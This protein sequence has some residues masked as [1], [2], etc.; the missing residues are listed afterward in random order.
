MAGLDSDPLEVVIFDVLLIA[1]AAGGR[2]KRDDRHAGDVAV[3]R[4]GFDR[5]RPE[6]DHLRRPLRYRIRLRPGLERVGP[7]AVGFDELVDLGH[8][9]NGLVQGDDDLL[10]VGDVLG[11]ERA[12]LP[13]LEPLVADLV[14]ADV[15]IP[16][17]LGYAHEADSAA[18]GGAVVVT[19]HRPPS[20]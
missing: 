4:R 20:V 19:S 17:F 11:R 18:L 5:A 15:E 16:D 7:A 2:L 12:S 9:A 3:L 1:E 10:V 13:V 6:R 8:Y 14:A